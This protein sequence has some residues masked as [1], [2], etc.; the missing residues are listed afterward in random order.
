MKTWT[1][2]QLYNILTKNIEKRIIKQQFLKNIK[3]IFIQL[4]EIINITL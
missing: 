2:K 4:F 3:S 1:I